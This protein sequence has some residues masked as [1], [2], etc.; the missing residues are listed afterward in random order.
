LLV[1][2]TESTDAMSCPFEVEENNT[3]IIKEMITLKFC[4]FLFYAYDYIA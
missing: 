1:K 2:W 3:M 4:L